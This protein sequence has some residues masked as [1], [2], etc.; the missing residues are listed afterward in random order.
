MTVIVVQGLDLEMEPEV[1]HEMLDTLE[2]LVDL[3]NPG[4]LREEIVKEIFEKLEKKLEE[5]EEAKAQRRATV[6]EGDFDE[7]DQEMLMEE[8]EL[9]EECMKQ[10]RNLFLRLESVFC[11]SFSVLSSVLS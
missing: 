5:M 7:E 6:A 8:N 1:I 9:D 4:L 10:V 3:A 2:Q 11:F